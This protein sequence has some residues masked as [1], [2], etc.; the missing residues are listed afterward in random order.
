MRQVFRTRA[1]A[2]RAGPDGLQQI[3][4]LSF[5]LH[6][7]P[8]SVGSSG[9]GLKVVYERNEDLQARC[10]TR[11]LELLDSAGVDGAFV[12]TFTMP[13]FPHAD[14]PV[15]DLDADGYSLVKS[16]PRGRPGTAHPDLPWDPSSPS[17]P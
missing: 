3:E 2:D 6:Q 10:L 15:H 9:P 13:L 14:D 5:V 17:P 11:Q 7:C 8:S 1:G 16:R 12:Y 4:P